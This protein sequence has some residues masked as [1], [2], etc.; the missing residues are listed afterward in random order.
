MMA[1]SL[2]ACVEEA[3]VPAPVED[4]TKPYVRVDDTA[5]R[6]LDV[7]GSDILVPFVRSSSEGTTDVTVAISDTSGIFTLKNTT[8]SSANGETTA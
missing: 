3:Y 4:L 2:A 8:V 1:L 5:S 6:N 7:D